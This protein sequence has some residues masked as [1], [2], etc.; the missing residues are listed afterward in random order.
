MAAR[1]GLR[2]QR[3]LRCATYVLVFSFSCFLL[4]LFCFANTKQAP[5]YR[6]PKFLLLF[7]LVLVSP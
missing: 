7:V 4:I 3:P 5:R 6:A 2:N 1:T